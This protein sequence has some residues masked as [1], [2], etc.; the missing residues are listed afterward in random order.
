MSDGP[1]PREVVFDSLRSGLTTDSMLEDDP[2]ALRVS[3]IAW[4]SGFRG[5]G[6][7]IGDQIIAVNGETISRPTELR[8]LQRLTRELPGGLN[9]ADVFAARGLKDGSP[10]TVTIR[11]RRYPGEGWFTE[12]VTGQ[13]RAERMYSYEGG[14]R[15]MGPTGPDS[16]ANDGFDGPWSSWYEKRVFDWTRV[17]DGSW[18]GRLNTRSTLKGHLEEKPRVDLLSEKY[19]GP[20]ADSVR[21]DWE[22]VRKCLDGRRYTLAPEDLDFRQLEEERARR[23]ASAATEGWNAFLAQHAADVIDASVP[24]DP[25]R[26]D[27]SRITGKLVA[28]P[29][30]APDQWVVSINRNFLSS[31]QNGAWYFVPADSPAMRRAF[32]AIERY[33]VCEEF[34]SRQHQA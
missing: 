5:S 27:R 24:V 10:L 26:G 30:I 33:N 14:R 23:V 12:S 1:Y 31:E 7:Q 28:L 15:G 11:R 4:D 19:P 16:L 13:V 21:S 20:F 22:A 29:P 2:P 18:Q 8:E 9:E 34:H 6:L 25:I 3:W 32:I 17:L